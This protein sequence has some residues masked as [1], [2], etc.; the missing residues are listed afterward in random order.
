[1]ESLHRVRYVAVIRSRPLSDLRADPRSELFDP[2][3]AAI[4]RQRAGDIEE[5]FWL[6]FVFVHFGKNSRGG[7]RYAREVYGRLGDGQLWNWA[8][9]SADP[10]QFRM[11]LSANQVAIARKT[12]PGGFGNHRKYESLSGDSDTGTGAAV[13]SYVNWIRPPRTHSQ[14]MDNALRHSAG[15][16]RG[17]FRQLY[18]EMDSVVRF[19]RT[20]RF[21]YLSMVGKLGLA[22]IEPDSTYVETATGPA[23]GARLLFAADAS[24]PVANSDLNNWVNTLEST[25]GVGMQVLED[26]LCNWQ[27]SP[28]MFMAFRG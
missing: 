11:W 23:K 6:I 9:V 17:A 24:A 27:K 28:D 15:N 22:N 25:L 8:K 7:W 1:M 13:E 16:P 3:K 19:G 12:P 18:E 2:L 5:A 26:A 14:V 20:A 10:G 21:D 4:I